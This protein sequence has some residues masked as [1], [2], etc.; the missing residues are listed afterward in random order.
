MLHIDFGDGQG[1]VAARRHPNGGGLVAMSAHVDDTVYLAADAMVFGHAK[2]TDNV[3]ITGRAKISGKLYRPNVSTLIEG[4]ASICG[5]VE[6][7]CCVLVSGN[8]EIRGN[9]KLLGGVQV[10]HHA[11]IDGNVEL[12]GDVLVLDRSFISGNIKIIADDKQILIKGDDNIQGN[13]VIKSTEQ[14]RASTSADRT[15]R[16]GRG[17]SDIDVREERVLGI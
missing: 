11:V 9:V 13:R 12:S 4:N 17:K 6:I 16:R 15:R 1:Y 7:T 5:N 3:R 10:T 2:V 14:L 8:A